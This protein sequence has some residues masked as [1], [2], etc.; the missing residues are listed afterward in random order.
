MRVKV[1][2]SRVR[3]RVVRSWRTGLSA[4]DRKALRIARLA[5]KDRGYKKPKDDKF[6]RRVLDQK[7]HDPK[8]QLATKELIARILALAQAMSEREFYPY[9]IELGY[10]IIESLLLHDG[11]VITALISRQSGKTEVLSSVLCAVAVIFPKLA[12]QYPDDWKL[13]TT[14]E[15]GVYR[16]FADGVKIG[17]YAPRLEQANIMFDRIK[18]WL[19][20]DTSKQVL[21]SLKLKVVESNGDRVTLTNGSRILCQSASEQSKIEGETHHLLVLEEAQDISDTKVRKSLHP[22]VS[23]LLGSIVKIGTANTKKCDFYEAIKKNERHEVLTGRRNNF[24]FPY[25]ITQ[26][27]NS[28]YRKYIQREKVL[29]GEDS[30]DFRMSYGCEWIFERGMFLTQA[31]LFHRGIAQKNGLFSIRH[32]NG[33]HRLLR[34]YSIVVGIDWGASSDSTVLTM[35]AVDW[36]SPTES[37]SYADLKGERRY[38][39]YQKHVIDWI[40]FIGDNYEYQWGEI[41]AYLKSLPGLKKV[42][43]DS[44]TAGKPIFDR[45]NAAF[46]GTGIEIVDFNFNRKIKSDGYKNLYGDFCRKSITFPCSKPARHT[47]HWRKFVQQLLDLQ[48]EY[49][50]G[51][52]RVKHPDEKGAHDDYPDSLMMAS[53]GANAPSSFGSIEFASENP[54]FNN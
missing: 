52:M 39:Y 15:K 29:L 50:Q 3:V 44:N 34:Q 45:M 19:A 31:Q 36:N 30:D 37:G 49:N 18:L 4:D 46:A 47:K 35:L 14:D 42:V 26:R 51:E 11:D 25:K 28:H 5:E 1:R 21:A 12:D 6:E 23:S 53:W 22:M 48:K 9:Q 40:E 24:F 10:R 27:Y 33:L 8:K 41:L 54:F 43:T 7:N 2:S 20:S 38:T 16:G 17:I 32:P 13:N